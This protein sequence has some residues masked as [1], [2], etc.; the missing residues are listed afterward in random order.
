MI[1]IKKESIEAAYNAW[2][3]IIKPE[4][5][6]IFYIHYWVDKNGQLKEVMYSPSYTENQIISFEN[7][8]VLN[9]DQYEIV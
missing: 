7:D 5:E 2:K 1:Q 6:K 8:H 4:D 3:N 9:S